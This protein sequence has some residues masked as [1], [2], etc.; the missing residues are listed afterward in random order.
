MAQQGYCRSYRRPSGW[1]PPL[2]L[3]ASSMNNMA[4]TSSHYRI[5]IMIIKIPLPL[6]VRVTKNISILP[7]K[8]LGRFRSYKANYLSYA[9][10]L[11][12]INVAAFCLTA[13]GPTMDK[14]RADIFDIA[15][16]KHYL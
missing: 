11:T 2:Y 5:H 13:V 7:F 6:V 4:A 3:S 12:R 15:I 1:N 10:S 16:F 14:C 8:F 9:F